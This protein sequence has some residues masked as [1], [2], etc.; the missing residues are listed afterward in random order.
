MRPTKFGI[1]RPTTVSAVP[2]QAASADGG[3]AARSPADGEGA[4]ADIPEVTDIPDISIG[5][6]APVAKAGTSASDGP[7]WL[8]S[9]SSI[10]QAAA[11]GAIGA[12][13][14]LL[15]QNTQTL[16]F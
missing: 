13:A 9:L 5:A 16:Y 12:L 7:A 1:K 10:V 4:V 8:W 6:S 3:D 15:Y 11:C 2:K 14:W